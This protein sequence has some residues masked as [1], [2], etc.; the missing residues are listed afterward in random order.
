MHGVL[1]LLDRMEVAEIPGLQALHDGLAALPGYRRCRAVKS[2][3][4][5]SAIGLMGS[6]SGRS[7]E[8]QVS[9]GLA[10]CRSY[11]PGFLHREANFHALEIIVWSRL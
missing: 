11:N 8:R 2:R 6:S 9:P 5:W 10:P 3:S 4:G 7:P 1:W